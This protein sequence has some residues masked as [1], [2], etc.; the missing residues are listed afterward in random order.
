MKYLKTT[1][2]IKE[3][4]DRDEFKL[5]EKELIALVEKYVTNQIK[6]GGRLIFDDKGN[7]IGHIRN[8]ERKED[9]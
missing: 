9:K 8:I 5:M 3:Y 2:D 4:F 7:V 6:Y 1:D